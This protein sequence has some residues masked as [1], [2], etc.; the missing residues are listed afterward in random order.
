[1]LFCAGWVDLCPPP[2]HHAPPPPLVQVAGPPSFGAT[3]GATGSAIH[4]TGYSGHPVRGQAGQER[5]GGG[6]G[7][8]NK[9]GEG[10]EGRGGEG[11]LSLRG[12]VFGNRH[13]AKH[14]LCMCI[15]L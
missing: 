7:G 12:S 14:H 6:R 3:N 8:E 11:S 5:G 10:R 4:H 9:G 15:K 13:T 2:G 1:M